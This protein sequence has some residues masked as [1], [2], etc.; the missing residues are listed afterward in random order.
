RRPARGGARGGRGGRPWT[1]AGA[2]ERSAPCRPGARRTAPSARGR[3]R[4]AGWWWTPGCADSA[5]SGGVDRWPSGEL[6]AQGVG[7]SYK[8]LPAA[9]ETAD[10]FFSGFGS[11]GDRAEGEPRRVAR[12]VDGVDCFGGGD[13]H[14]ARQLVESKTL[15]DLRNLGRFGGLVLSG[16]FLAQTHARSTRE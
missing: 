12:R 9:A 3:R 8:I 11:A 5:S 16:R 15:C 6:T 14:Q 4:R 1:H 2:P 10:D 13:Q 7:H